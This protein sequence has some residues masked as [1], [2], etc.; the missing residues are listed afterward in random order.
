[1][2]SRC[3]DGCK[4]KGLAASCFGSVL[5]ERVVVEMI[6]DNAPGLMRSASKCCNAAKG[7]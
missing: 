2:A 5:T 6:R 4:T 3:T 7:K 1:M